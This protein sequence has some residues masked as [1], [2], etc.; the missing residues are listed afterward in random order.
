M[1]DTGRGAAEDPFAIELAPDAGELR[2]RLVSD[3]I[4]YGLARVVATGSAFVMVLFLARGLQPQL[5][6]RFTLLVNVAPFLGLVTCT[7]VGAAAFRYFS[8]YEKEGSGQR[9]LTSTARQLLLGGAVSALAAFLLRGFLPE[10]TGWGTAGWLLL[11]AGAGPVGSCIE[12]LRAQRRARLYLLATTWVHLLPLLILIGWSVVGIISLSGVFLVQGSVAISALIVFVVWW[13]LGPRLSAPSRSEMWA[14]FARHGLPLSIA[15]GAS[16]VLSLADRYIIGLTLGSTDVGVYTLAYQLSSA[17]ILLSFGIITSALGPLAHQTYD[18][19]GSAAGAEVVRQTFALVLL[20]C[21]GIFVAVA[22]VREPLL[23]VVGGSSFS[24]GAFVV[25]LVAAGAMLLTLG[26][27][28]EQLMSLRLQTGRILRNLL[29]GAGINLAMNAVLIPAL[30]LPGAGIA[31]VIGY[32]AYLATAVWGLRSS[33]S[34]ATDTRWLVEFLIAAALASVVAALS[35]NLFDS[36]RIRLAFGGVTALLV[37]LL[38][39]RLFTSSNSLLAIASSTV[40]GA[41]TF[42]KAAL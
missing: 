1:S 9:M 29:V 2:E 25:P 42:D 8:M 39:L 35:L 31:T 18:R 10:T 19:F 17:P 40:K 36:D 12:L 5:L 16:Q 34:P 23:T 6:G 26:M 14:R 30:G 28:L 21:G 15:G 27:A 11:I 41:R 7:W 3:S 38:V 4:F 13:G 37:Y 33:D 22:A 24:R 20:V 32:L